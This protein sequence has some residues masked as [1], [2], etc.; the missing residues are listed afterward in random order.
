[1]TSLDV[2]CCHFAQVQFC[3]LHHGL[4]RIHVQSFRPPILFYNNARKKLEGFMRPHI[5]KMTC[6]V[7]VC[8]LADAAGQ[9]ERNVLC[10]GRPRF[11]EVSGP[12]DAWP[13]AHF[14][15]NEAEQLKHALLAIMTKTA[16]VACA[17]LLLWPTTEA[18]GTL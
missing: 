12:A 7:C 5:Y 10:G 4:A 6:C 15:A 8:A 2:R 13:R 17:N 16:A 11:D 1:M 18:S 9:S 14:S 3:L